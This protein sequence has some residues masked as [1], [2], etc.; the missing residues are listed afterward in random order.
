[1]V[2]TVAGKLPVP[3]KVSVTDNS[4]PQGLGALRPGALD[5]RR[6]ETSDP[7]VLQL[8]ASLYSIAQRRSV[9]LVDLEY[10]GENAD[11]AVATFAAQLSHSLPGVACSGWTW[12]DKVDPEGIRKL[13]AE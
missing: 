10:R 9:G 8:S 4:Q 5:L 2:L 3:K 12:N 7:N 6:K 11:D 13:M 1:M